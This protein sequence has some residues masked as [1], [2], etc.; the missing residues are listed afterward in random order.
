MKFS[1]SKGT[2]NSTSADTNTKGSNNMNNNTNSGST[3]MDVDICSITG[4]IGDSSINRRIGESSTWGGL[5][6]SCIADRINTMR[7]QEAEAYDYARYSR[8]GD[9]LLEATGGEVPLDE[10][11]AGPTGA[12]GLDSETQDVRL[13][14]SW[15]EKICHW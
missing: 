10:E 9:A 11:M 3:S 1:L 8:L 13:N 4:S 15:R 6:A 7:S 2:R 5:S 14:S 12:G